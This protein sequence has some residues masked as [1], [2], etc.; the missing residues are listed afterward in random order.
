MI[1]IE[2][3]MRL[4]ALAGAVTTPYDLVR[5]NFRDRRLEVVVL[6]EPPI[7]PALCTVDL[8]RLFDGAAITWAPLY[9]SLVATSDN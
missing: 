9:R 8:G 7:P 6:P 2:Q 4:V 1:P 3:Q 5:Y